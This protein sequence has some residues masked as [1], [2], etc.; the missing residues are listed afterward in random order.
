MRTVKQGAAEATTYIG[1]AYEKHVYGSS[2]SYAFN[3]VIPSR[4]IGQVTWSKTDSTSVFYADH[5]GSPETVSDSSQAG[6]VEKDEYDPFGE[7]R[8]PSAISS[9]AT[10]PSPRSVG[11]KGSHPKERIDAQ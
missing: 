3:L 4:V 10:L 9:P 5:L 1:S 6:T 2:E 8:N 11:F 7:R